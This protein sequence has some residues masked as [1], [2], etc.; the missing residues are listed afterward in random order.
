MN[1]HPLAHWA[2]S[3]TAAPLL[4]SLLGAE[5]GI[6]WENSGPNRPFKPWKIRIFVNFWW[7]WFSADMENWSMESSDQLFRGWSGIYRLVPPES[8]LWSSQWSAPFR[9][10]NPLDSLNWSKIHPIR[11]DRDFWT[12]GSVPKKFFTKILRDENFRCSSEF[13]GFFFQGSLIIN[14]W[15]EPL[16]TLRERSLISSD[17]DFITFGTSDL[18]QGPPIVGGKTEIFDFPSWIFV[19]FFSRHWAVIND[20][21]H[22]WRRL[23]IILETLKLGVAW[24]LIR[25]AYWN[26]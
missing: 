5:E 9:F 7:I 15:L 19:I 8:P 6:F 22:F 18:S 2:R 26:P 11:A 17:Q 24:S 21:D 1:C 23:L 3:T 14:R 10:W 20:S 16:I 4:L 25:A 13:L 12:F